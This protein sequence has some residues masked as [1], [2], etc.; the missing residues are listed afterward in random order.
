MGAWD[1]G[2]FDN[3]GAMDFVADLR[4]K[5]SPAEATAFVR[6]TMTFIL[7]TTE[8]LE[9]PDVAAAIAAACVVA[10]TMDGNGGNDAKEAALEALNGRL[11]EDLVKVVLDKE[12]EAELREFARRVFLRADAKKDNEW[13]DLWEDAGR[14]DV[15]AKENAPFRKALGMN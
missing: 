15:V 2:P 12:K 6:E 9:G 13:F 14:L 11:R 5:T 8:Y 1:M 4:H 10:I 3:D 7:D